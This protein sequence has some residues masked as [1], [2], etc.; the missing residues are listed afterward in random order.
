M[1]CVPA[2]AAARRDK[3][4]GM[5]LGTSSGV[6]NPQPQLIPLFSWAYRRRPGGEKAR[7]KPFRISDCGLRIEG[8]RGQ[9]CKVNG[10]AVE[11][12]RSKVEGRRGEVTADYADVR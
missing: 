12:A 5:N 4:G 2:P 9:R 10:K 8:R 6:L 11:G 3:L 1:E 7:G